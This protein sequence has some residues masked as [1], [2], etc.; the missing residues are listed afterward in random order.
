MTVSKTGSANTWL[1]KGGTDSSLPVPAF[2]QESGGE[3]VIATTGSQDAAL[4]DWHDDGLEY[5]L[6]IT[7]D[8]YVMI[9][10]GG[11]IVPSATGTPVAIWID[12][13]L[14]PGE[15]LLLS[16]DLTQTAAGAF[17]LSANGTLV[18]ARFDA[19]KMQL[20]QL[21]DYTAITP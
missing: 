8:P 9:D 5:E 18:L 20:L 7:S 16:D 17:Y 2:W 3:Y 15:G 13:P 19:A 21:G 4:V 14:N 12:D 11:E 1:E 10:S 6:L